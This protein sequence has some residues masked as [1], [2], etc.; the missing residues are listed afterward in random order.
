MIAVLDMLDRRPSWAM[1]EW[2]PDRLRAALE[3]VEPGSEL[4]VA[5]AVSD[6]SGDGATRA[7]PDVL[8]AVEDADAYFGYGVAPGILERGRRLRWVH[9]G[10]AGVGASLTPEMLDSEVVFT[11]SAGIHGPPMAET[12][13]AMVLHFFRG[14]DLAT[15]SQRRATWNPEPFY[16]EPGRLR[17]V[18]GATVGLVGLG[19]VGSEIARRF[20]ALGARV[21][22]VRRSAR[23]DRTVLLDTPAGGEVRVEVLGGNGALGRLAE[24]SDVLVVTVPATP[25]TRGMIG[26]GIVSRMHPGALLVNV[27]RGGVVDE[28]SVLDALE[29]GALRAAAFDVFAVEPLPGDD[30]F[31]KGRGTLVTPHVS[32]VTD[33]YW[34]RE[35]ELIAENV[36]RLARDEPLLNVVDKEEGY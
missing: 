12:V 32:A 36:R 29:A 27:A 25:A 11:N 21:A 2:V 23:A 7:H 28:A 22:A 34:E 5:T 20:G 30:R 10:S 26:A 19:G 15:A 33:G 31:W 13:L 6:G 3:A 4:R 24:R 16:R 18:A 9:S 17:E 8:R 14:L 35:V 1:P